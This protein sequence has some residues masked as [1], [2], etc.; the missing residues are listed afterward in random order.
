MPLRSPRG[1]LVVTSAAFV[2]LALAELFVGTVGPDTVIRDRLVTIASPA[3]IAA[4]RVVNVAGDWRF[5]LP[6]TLLLFVVF[7]RARRA[8]WVW[9]TLMIAAPLAEGALKIVVGRPR[10]EGAAFGFPSGHATAAAAYFGAVLYLS[11]SLRPEIRRPLRL[12]ATV[13]IVLV[14]IA[15]VMLR[16]HWPSDVLGGFALGLA[17]ASAAAVLAVRRDASAA[18]RRA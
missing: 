9:T 11:E 13:M 10:P 15:R 8:W 2:V 12:I 6:A 14:G 18:D 1:V 16:A 3:V 5:L 7:A 4:M 17:L